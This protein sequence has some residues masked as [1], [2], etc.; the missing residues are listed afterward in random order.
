MRVIHEIGALRD[1]LADTAPVL[2]PTMGALH[3]GHA[4]LIRLGASLGASLGVP[5]VVSVFVNPTQFG[6]GE[7]FDRYPR[8]FEADVETATASGATIVFAPD[9]E[10]VYPP[11]D[12]PPV[13]PLPA[14]AREPGLEDAH[15]PGHFAGVLQVVA[16]LFD[17]VGP[18]T[19]VFGEKDWQQ[20][21]AVRAM[22]EVEAASN[23][24]RWPGLAIVAH[25]TLREPGGLAHSSRNRHLSADDRRRALGLVRAL[26]AA[27]NTAS[28]AGAEDAMRRTLMAHEV[29]IDYA[30]IRDASTLLPLGPDDTRG[31][32]LVAGR[33]GDVRLIDNA[34]WRAISG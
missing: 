3:D 10:A 32:A 17:L 18:A 33:V 29:A 23:P 27:A 2:V 20:L 24:R 14:V 11:C 26:R 30:A 31:R 34:P 9:A 19:A 12:P 5:V 8:G 1:A 28:V 16:R 4:A 21:C 15:R 6:P 25:P 13:P 7:D 22:V